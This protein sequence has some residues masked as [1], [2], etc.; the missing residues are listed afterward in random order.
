MHDLL[1]ARQQ[2]LARRDLD[3][4]AAQLGLDMARFSAEMDDEVY[5]QRVREHMEGARRSHVRGTPG[6]FV[7]GMI[8][9]VSF[10]LQGLLD[11][12]E[13]ALHRP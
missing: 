2:H 3:A 12:T 8:Q 10:G 5:L 13:S 1:F 7:N 11:S 4:Y 9:D 6:F